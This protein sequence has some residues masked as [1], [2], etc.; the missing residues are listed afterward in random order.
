LPKIPVISIIDDD[1]AVRDATESLVRS[2]GYRPYTFAS[3]EEFLN[4]ERLHDTSCLISDLQ[5][6][7]MSGT[8]LQARLIAG[9]HSLPV[10][11]ITAFPADNARVRAMRAGAVCFLSK[12]YDDED[13]IRCIDT[14]LKGA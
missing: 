10:I 9:G 2:L 4:S 11:I 1:Q 8:E 13:L 5:M 14:A 7:G 3:A 6:P 12:P